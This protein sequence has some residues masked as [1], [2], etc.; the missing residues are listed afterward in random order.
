MCC[1]MGHVVMLAGNNF[2]WNLRRGNPTT[3]QHI[4]D[5]SN[6][7]NHSST[8]FQDIQVTALGIRGMELIYLKKP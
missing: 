6:F 8:H 5:H 2:G 4:P 7:N 3:R 1:G